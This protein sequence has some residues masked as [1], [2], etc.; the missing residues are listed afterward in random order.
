[1][2]IVLVVLSFLAVLLCIY[3]CYEGI[4][5]DMLLIRF[6]DR[7]RKQAAKEYFKIVDKYMKFLN[8]I[9]RGK[10]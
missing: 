6:R 10:K 1:M 9:E 4:K 8:K 3:L 5:T 2:I 7:E